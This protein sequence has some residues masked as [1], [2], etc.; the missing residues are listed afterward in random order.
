[1]LFK[2]SEWFTV[3]KNPAKNQISEFRVGLDYNM[4]NTYKLFIFEKVGL[5]DSV[6]YNIC[7]VSSLHKNPHKARQKA[8]S[9]YEKWVKSLEKGILPIRT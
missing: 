1:M 7:P 9:L 8:D 6:I 3:K 2:T 4:N 5:Y